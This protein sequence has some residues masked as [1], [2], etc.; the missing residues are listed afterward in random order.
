MILEAI[1][2]GYFEDTSH[3]FRPYRS[4]HTALGEIKRK[5]TGVKWFIEGDIKGFF[6]NIDHNVMIDILSERIADER[7]LRLMRK[8]L[9]AGYIEHWRYHT[10]YSGTPQGGIISPILANVYLD[11]FDK[12]MDGVTQAFDKGKRRRTSHDYNSVLAQRTRLRR[13]LAKA[14]NDEAKKEIMAEIKAVE[15]KLHQ[16]PFG[17]NM[18][19][20]FRRI[21]YVRYA[22]DF[23]VGVIGSKADCV[24]L[25]AQITQYMNDV[26]KLE[27][28]KEK[29]LITHSEEK[30]KFLGYEIYVQRSN[31][32]TKNSNGVPVRNFSGNVRLHVPSDIVRKKLI[33]LGAMS[34]RQTK[35]KEVWWAESRTSLVHLEEHEIVARYNLEIRGFYNYYSIANNIAAMGGTFGDIMKCSCYKTLAHKH[36][37]TIRKEKKRYREGQDFVVRYTDP[38]GN[39]KCRVLYN[40]GF[41]KK[42]VSDFAELDV[43]PQ[44][45]I[46]PKLS[47][48]ERLKNGICE[49]CGQRGHL[50]MHHIRALRE[51]TGSNEWE[52][53]MLKSKRKTL[54]V[55]PTCMSKIMSDAK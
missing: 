22:D 11:N 28:S 49:L 14:E 53:R 39:E 1:Y 12:Y 4:Y 33:E 30:A 10:T 18:D 46:M 34:I 2:E 5:F 8:F 6:D 41:K 51:L 20:T 52:R 26:L 50:T 7:F 40:E 36:N 29:T 19:E 15:V 27:L 31:A 35:S 25:K 55:C 48:V 17:D 32:M 45:F 38:K 3:G 43:L 54:A 21:K 37:S 9:N 13:H 16:I 23:L 42:A 44:Q 47:L 24:Q